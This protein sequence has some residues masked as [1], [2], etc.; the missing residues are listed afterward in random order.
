MEEKCN[1]LLEIKKP[2]KLLNIFCAAELRINKNDA[3]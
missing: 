3:V 1:A 2:F